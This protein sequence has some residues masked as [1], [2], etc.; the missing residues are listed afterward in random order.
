VGFEALDRLRSVLADF[1]Y[2]AVGIA[3][4]ATPFPAVVVERLGKEDRSFGAPVV[5][6]G[7][8]VGDGQV[9]KAAQPVWIGRGFKDDFGLVGCGAATGIEN[10]SGVGQLDLT[11]IFGLDHFPAKNSKVKV[12]GFFL[13]SDGEEMGDQ[14]AFVCNWRVGENP[15]HRAPLSRAWNPQ[16]MCGVEQCQ[17]TSLVKFGAA[18]GL[19]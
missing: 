12:L 10:D 13:I 6:A 3:H 11:G 1:D 7:P 16:F 17:S 19:R 9:E 8:D 14:E 5:V 15:I 18:S 4:V 2:V